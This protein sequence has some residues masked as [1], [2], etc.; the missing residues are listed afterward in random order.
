MANKKEIIKWVEIQI[1]KKKKAL[2]RIDS[3]SIS[4]IIDRHIKDPIYRY[5]IEKNMIGNS[6]YDEELQVYIP[7]I[8]DNMKTL[9]VDAGIYSSVARVLDEVDTMHANHTIEVR[10]IRMHNDKL[11]DLLASFKEGMLLISNGD[12]ADYAKAFIESIKQ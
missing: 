4:E 9:C 11:N 10:E 7:T 3:N 2:P 5:T 12:L 1:N 8:D 6:K